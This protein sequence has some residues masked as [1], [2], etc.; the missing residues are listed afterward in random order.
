M[1]PRTSVIMIIT[2]TL[3][4]MDYTARMETFALLVHVYRGLLETVMTLIHAP[5]TP[6]MTPRINV[7]M[8]TCVLA[9]TLA[10]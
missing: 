2:Q 9:R 1:K 4:M 5:R 8:L 6:A 3:V 7:I 10:R